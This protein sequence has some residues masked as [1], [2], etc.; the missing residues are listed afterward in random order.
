MGKF[1]LDNKH[2]W[3]RHRA[4]KAHK[5]RLAAGGSLAAT[6]ERLDALRF[7]CKDASVPPKNIRISDQGQAH[8]AVI[9][10][11]G[12]IGHLDEGS[13][14]AARQFFAENPE[15]SDFCPAYIVEAEDWSGG[16][17]VRVGFDPR[18]NRK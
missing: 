3:F 16:Y 5:K 14:K 17:I 7:Y 8:I 4:E 1:Y 12:Y 10:A 11:N 15:F 6:T 9:G 13:S 2:K 18:R